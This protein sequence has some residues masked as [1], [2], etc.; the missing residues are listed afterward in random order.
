M[1]I[2]IEYG[3]SF[4]NSH[5]YTIDTHDWT[6]YMDSCESAG[7]ASFGLICGAVLVLILVVLFTQFKMIQKKCC[8]HTY[9]TQHGKARCCVPCIAIL[10]PLCA[11]GAII[12]Y[13]IQCIHDAQGKDVVTANE[14]RVPHGVVHIGCIL[15][16]PLSR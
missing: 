11:C 12:F 10:A 15:A 7:T 6:M 1:I 16:H 2:F 8:P 9:N 13:F 14:L 5:K 3:Q 4:D